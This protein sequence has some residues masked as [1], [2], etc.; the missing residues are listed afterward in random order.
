METVSECVLSTLVSSAWD[1]HSRWGCGPGRGQQRGHV[2]RWAVPMPPSSD[3]LHPFSL[4][5][6]QKGQLL[7]S[8]LLRVSL[9]SDVSMA[10]GL[11]YIKCLGRSI[12][13]NTGRELLHEA[14]PSPWVLDVSSLPHAHRSLLSP[15]LYRH[16]EPTALP[17]SRPGLQPAS[18]PGQP[19]DVST[20]PMFPSNPPE[21]GAGQEGMPSLTGA[22]VLTCSHQRTPRPP[23]HCVGD[24]H[25][26]V[27][28]SRSSAG[29][30][31]GLAGQQFFQAF[32]LFPRTLPCAPC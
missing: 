19:L 28:P 17:A 5:L 20:S 8:T 31:C 2:P 21:R 25:P 12:T 24:V 22:A 10:M 14:W 1:R 7:L 26:H 3:V 4:S 16:G 13:G 9:T 29:R 30:S 27:V 6:V 18:R 23:A 32:Q 15:S 11:D